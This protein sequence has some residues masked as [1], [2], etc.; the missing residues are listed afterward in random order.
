[1]WRPFDE[2]LH[3]QTLGMF[4]NA[5]L[6]TSL[7]AM[8][9]VSLY[10]V[11]KPR[12]SVWGWKYNNEWIFAKSKSMLMKMWI[13]G[14]T[15]QTSSNLFHFPSAASHRGDSG[16]KPQS[17]IWGRIRPVVAKWR[18][19]QSRMRNPNRP[20]WKM[21]SAILIFYQTLL[22]VVIHSQCMF[23]PQ[24]GTGSNCRQFLGT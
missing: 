5:F 10:L 13:C 20:V 7:D 3:C 24:I 4:T 16:T 14:Q 1:M 19:L 2:R 8:W 12:Y 15:W 17:R 23:R 22:M 6:S 21:K 11:Q 18:L 9:N